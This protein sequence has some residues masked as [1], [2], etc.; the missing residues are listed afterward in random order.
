MIGA[1]IH[2]DVLAENGL[3]HQNGTSRRSDNAMGHEFST[4]FNQIALHRART[5]Q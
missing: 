1:L 3:V 4:T 2:S 5:R